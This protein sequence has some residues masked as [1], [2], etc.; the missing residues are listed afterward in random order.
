M[1][2]GI[3]GWIL[4]GGEDS[5]GVSPE[6]W[7][8]DGSNWVQLADMPFAAAD[9]A[10]VHVPFERNRFAFVG[11]RDAAGQLRDDVFERTQDAAWLDQDT[12]TALT[13]RRDA[14]LLDHLHF[15]ASSPNQ[16]RATALVFGGTRDLNVYTQSDNTPVFVGAEFGQVTTAL[17]CAIGINPNVILFNMA[18]APT[19]PASF[20]N[21]AF[22]IHAPFDP[23][24]RGAVV[25]G[26]GV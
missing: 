20:G 5:S 4:F 3:E 16:F 26:T 14:V 9:A 13:P 15:V 1:D 24:L 23:V 21:A 22:P 18:T 8:F 7:R 10:V 19:S 25:P 12:V 17:P 11:G 2:A 6:S